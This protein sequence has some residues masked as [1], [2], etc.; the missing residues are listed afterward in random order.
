MDR[1]HLSLSLSSELWQ[2]LLGAAL[3]VKLAKGDVD[4]LKDTRRL[5]GQLEVRRRVAGL[6]EDRSTPRALVRIKDRAK[7]EWGDRKAGM[8]RRI[9]DLVQ[10]QAT[11]TI[12]L[13]GLGTELAYGTQAVQADAFVRASAD[14]HV[15]LLK[16]NID[17]PFHVERRFGASVTL[18]KIRFSREEGA[19]VGNLEDLAVH[20]GEHVALQLTARALEFGL[21]QRLPGVNPL[22]ILKKEQVEGLV[23]PLGGMF[24]VDMGVDELD[25]KVDGNTLSLNVKFGFTQPQL[26]ETVSVEA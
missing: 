12:E 15:R 19:V 2:E 8:K 5:I 6:L 13:D 7:K 11:W 14:G 22:T 4:V 21:E 1:H 26:T 17:L 24:R 20:L 10:V 16:E 9:T 3:P 18:G 25:L 23:A